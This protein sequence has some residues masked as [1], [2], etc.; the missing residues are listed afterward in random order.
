[1]FLK[2]FFAKCISWR[3]LHFQ[4][5]SRPIAKQKNGVAKDGALA[6]TVCLPDGGKNFRIVDVD[7]PPVLLNCVDQQGGTMS[8]NTNQTADITNGSQATCLKSTVERLFCEAPDRDQKR[9]RQNP[10]DGEVWHPD[11]NQIESEKLRA[12]RALIAQEHFAVTGPPDAQPLPLGFSQ[13]FKAP[14][15]LRKLAGYY[16][17]SLRRLNYDVQKHPCFYDYVCGVMAAY[18]RDEL[19]GFGFASNEEIQNIKNRY[20][21]CTLPGLGPGLIWY[22]REEFASLKR[23]FPRSFGGLK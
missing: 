7:L 5:L 16:S 12:W 10:V 13:R 22:P 9:L 21:P 1:L 17:D 18:E 23:D 11:E 19:V 2:H 20:P 15:L 8:T 14:G 4:R 6:I 3:A